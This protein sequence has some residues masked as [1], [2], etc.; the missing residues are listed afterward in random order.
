MPGHVTIQTPREGR[1]FDVVEI[2]WNDGRVEVHLREVRSDATGRPDEMQ[3]R[4]DGAAVT[5]IVGALV[6]FATD[7]DL[8]VI[9]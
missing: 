3:L 2:A 4:L 5:E 7:A 8:G 6:R 1:D 9:E